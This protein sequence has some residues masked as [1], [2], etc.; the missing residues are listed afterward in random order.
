MRDMS[1]PQ[2]YA[3]HNEFVPGK[4]GQKCEFFGVERTIAP[5]K[6][7]PGVIETIVPRCAGCGEHMPFVTN[8]D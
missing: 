3:C 2:V 1:Q 6:I 4:Y 5:R 8:G 7:A